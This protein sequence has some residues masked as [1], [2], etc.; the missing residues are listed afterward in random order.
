MPD[1]LHPYFSLIHPL[2]KTNLVPTSSSIYG[3]PARECSPLLATDGHLTEE[4]VQWYSF[5][6][7][8]GD[9]KP[10]FHTTAL[11]SGRNRPRFGRESWIPSVVPKMR[12]RPFSRFRKKN[13]RQKFLTRLFLFEFQK[14]GGKL[15]RHQLLLPLLAKKGFNAIKLC[16]NRVHRGPRPSTIVPPRSFVA[17]GNKYLGPWAHL[18][19]RLIYNHSYLVRSLIKYE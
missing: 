9:M 14:N 4:P 7:A 18:L 15:E 19:T 3:D 10:Q 6:T 8:D 1:L 12:S 11:F 5:C 16:I 2:A 13:P 17:R